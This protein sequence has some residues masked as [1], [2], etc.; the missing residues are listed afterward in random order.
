MMNAVRSYPGRLDSAASPE[1]PPGILIRSDPACAPV[2]FGWHAYT[3][4]GRPSK[5]FHVE[6][7]ER[8]RPDTAPGPFQGLSASQLRA[9]A[10]QRQG[11]LLPRLPRG[12]AWIGPQLIEEV[13]ED[14]ARHL[15]AAK[16]RDGTG[17][18]VD[19]LTYARRLAIEILAQRQ[20]AT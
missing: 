5:Y 10:V 4:S 19:A 18:K 7:F 16:L 12:Y 6:S 11:A 13:T 17:E 20:A 1:R 9:Y 2:S 3:A 15:G 8:L 14:A